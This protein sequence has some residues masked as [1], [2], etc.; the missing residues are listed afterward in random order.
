MTAYS[1]DYSYM[2]EEFGNIIVNADDEE[3]AEMFAKESVLETYPEISSAT[4]VFDSIK[5]VK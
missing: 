1:V 5:E 2:V 3:Q 4:L